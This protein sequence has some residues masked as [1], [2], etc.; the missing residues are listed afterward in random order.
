[1][2]AH[3]RHLACASVLAET[4]NLLESENAR[5][6]QRLFRCLRTMVQDWDHPTLDNKGI[7]SQPFFLKFGFTDASLSQLATEE[8]TLILT[9]DAPLYACLI[10]RKPLPLVENFTH[11]RFS[12]DEPSQQQREKDKSLVMFWREQLRL[13]ESKMEGNAQVKLSRTPW[14]IEDISVSKRK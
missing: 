6:D 8:E 1:L 2:L 14:Q 10:G 11:I 5:L 9:A 4:C 3:D 13:M 12:L 7:M